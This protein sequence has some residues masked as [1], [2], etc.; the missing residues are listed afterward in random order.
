MI[1]SN[2]SHTQE[3]VNMWDVWL[4]TRATVSV[5]VCAFMYVLTQSLWQCYP[6]FYTNHTLRNR[7]VVTRIT[8]LTFL[9][10]MHNI[11]HICAC[12]CVSLAVQT[13]S[14][15]AGQVWTGG[16]A[17]TSVTTS[18]KPSTASGRLL[19]LSCYEAC[20]HSSLIYYFGLFI[21][22]TLKWLV[23]WNW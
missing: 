23:V 18:V 20:R 8:S 21:I 6:L 11:C 1:L 16:A 17:T 2:H 9:E 12:S 22:K 5:S 19:M 15:F 4:E 14:Y 7:P 3:V 13:T 10:S